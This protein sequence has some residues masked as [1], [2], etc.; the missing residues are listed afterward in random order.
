MTLEEHKFEDCN[1]LQLSE[2]LNTVDPRHANWQIC[3]DKPYLFIRYVNETSR[4]L[5]QLVKKQLSEID[6]LTEPEA[7]E[8]LS[9]IAKY[10]SKFYKT[11]QSLGIDYYL[12][13]VSKNV[14]VSITSGFLSTEK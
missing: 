9:S 12:T 3:I 5:H 1:H 14:E 7:H 10:I 11:S 2:F 8:A 6:P 4:F 13:I